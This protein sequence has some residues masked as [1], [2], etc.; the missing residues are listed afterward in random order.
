MA[1]I[2]GAVPLQTVTLKYRGESD[3]IPVPCPLTVRGA[4]RDVSGE[5][6]LMPRLKGSCISND[7]TPRYPALIVKFLLP[8]GRSVAFE[9]RYPETKGLAFRKGIGKTFSKPRA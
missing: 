8:L 9:K 4:I 2:T 3:E 6:K 5:A 7:L 1:C